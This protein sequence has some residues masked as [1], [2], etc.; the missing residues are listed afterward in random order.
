MTSRAWLAV[1]IAPAIFPLVFAALL[2]GRGAAGQESGM[3]AGGTSSAVSAAATGDAQP[4]EL[5][6][7]DVVAKQLDTAR[8]NIQ[9]SL[10]ASTYEFGRAA[11]ETQPQ[12]DNQAFNRLLLQAPGVAQDSFGQLHVRGD[13][14]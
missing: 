13:H 4:I 3:A 7:L 10:G 5:G 9:P 6:E 12:G 11:I 14:G 2:A 8:R 1:R